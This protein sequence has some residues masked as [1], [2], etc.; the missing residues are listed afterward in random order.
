M[1]NDVYH[2]NKRKTRVR[3]MVMSFACIFL[4]LV[5]SETINFQETRP[6]LQPSSI[7]AATLSTVQIPNSIQNEI[8]NSNIRSKMPMGSTWR[9]MSFALKDNLSDDSHSSRRRG[10]ISSQNNIYTKYFGK[11]PEIALVQPTFTAAAYHNSFYI[12]YAK[13]ASDPTNKNISTDLQLLK[14]KVPSTLLQ[15][16]SI[17]NMLYLGNKLRET[18]PHSTLAFLTDIDAD[19]GAIFKD[20]VDGGTKK[21][22]NRYD[23]IIL[24]H[25][26]YV[27]QTEYNNFRKFVENGGKMII[28]DANVFYAEVSYDKLTNTIQLVKGH[29]WEFNSKSAWKSIEERWQNETKDWIGSNYLCYSCVIKFGNDPFGYVHHEENYVTNPNDKILLNF[30]AKIVNWDHVIPK[31]VVVAA[32][33]L[34]YGNGKVIDLGIYGDDINSKKIFGKFIDGILMSAILGRSIQISNF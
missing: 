11:G 3:I 33:E 1:S 8:K 9:P 2:H 16:T 13:H 31:Q 17:S 27:T 10:E 28:L 14:S 25:Q 29:G 19:K 32:Y 7:S 20:V 24:G 26:E 12:F 23:I 30:N 15:S 4:L 22:I 6:R 5:S 34:D 18:I 21:T